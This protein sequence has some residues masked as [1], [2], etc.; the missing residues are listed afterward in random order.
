MTKVAQGKLTDMSLAELIREMGEVSMSGALRVSRERAKAVVYF[1]NGSVVFVASNIRAHRLAEYL[2][3]TAIVGESFFSNLSPK[4]TDDEVL[5]RLGQV[6]RS[7]PD[8]ISSIR[9][10]HVADVL[11][12]LLLWTDGDWQFDSR[13]RIAGDT[14]VIIDA[15]R[16]LLESTRHLPAAY[17]SSRFGAESEQIEVA[18]LN[19]QMPDLLPAEAFVLSRVAGATSVKD[20]LA[21]SGLPED[22]TLR[23]IYAL[24]VCGAV[25]RG[26]WAAPRVNASSAPPTTVAEGGVN[27]ETLEDFFARLERASDHY[28][29]LGVARQASADELKNAY[30]ALARRYHPDRFHRA[31]AQLRNRIDSAFAR[32]ARAY[33]VLGDQS[34]RASYDAQFAPPPS[35]AEV[36]SD[37]PSQRTSETVDDNRA[38]SSFRK[39]VAAMKQNQPQQALRFLAEAASL[40]PRRARYRSE[41]GRAL[42]HDPKTR[43]T[44]E[45][46]LKAAIELEPENMA[47]RVALAELYKALGL[48]RRAAGELQRALSTD[49]KNAAARNL[50]ASLKN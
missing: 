48:R 40:E 30:H 19:G 8:A 28:E 13:V 26:A 42:I 5:K 12:G 34:S 37:R 1:E 49:P 7:R 33:E 41:Y 10:N 39:G 32:V 25:K 15:R 27:A 29:L 16:L 36:A 22:E 35:A 24:A 9:A 14:R 45:V 17:V 44:A 4:A 3:R 20:L 43:R 11:R 50:L 18:Q 46:E 21:L 2:K 31:D 47:H 23:A 38:E 6:G